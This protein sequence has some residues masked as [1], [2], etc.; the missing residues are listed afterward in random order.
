MAERRANFSAGDL[1][2]AHAR[3]CPI[4]GID[5][6]GHVTVDV[7][8]WIGTYP[9]RDVPHPDPEVLVR[10]VEREGLSGAWVGHLPSAFWRDPS[11]G[12]DTL[13]TAVERWPTMLRPVPCIR[14]GWP[15]W[16]RALASAVDRD[17]PAIR[18]Y[19]PP[20]GLAPQDERL[21]ELALACGEAGVAL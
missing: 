2:W 11:S 18:A 10:V 17:V 14:P 21:R 20:L 19:P 6:E 4:D 5:G 16:E 15:H 13:F 9:F 8:T 7:H 1:S 3:A 12:N